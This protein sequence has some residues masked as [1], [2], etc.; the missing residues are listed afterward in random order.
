[1]V[2][3][4]SLPSIAHNFGQAFVVASKERE[5]D[6]FLGR[7]LADARRTGEAT[8]RLDILTGEI[9]PAVLATPF[10]ARIIEGY[11][12]GFPELVIN[13]HSDMEHISAAR[14]ELTFELPAQEA[15]Q[16]AT[17]PIDAPYR[18]RVIIDDDKGKT[19]VAELEG[20]VHEER[21]GLFARIRGHF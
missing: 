9:T 13:G 14:M 4:K 8:L 19:W 17:S 21:A 3:Y 11:V 6:H 20:R 12:R 16:D 5:H 18:C 10:L 7:L 15:A 2:R 1:M